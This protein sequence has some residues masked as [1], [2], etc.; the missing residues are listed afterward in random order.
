[1]GRPTLVVQFRADGSGTEIVDQPLRVGFV[2]G[3]PVGPA[4]V[5]NRVRRRLRHLVR[6]RLAAL[7]PL[8]PGGVLIVRATPAAAG[9]TGVRL[10]ADLEAALARLTDQVE[11]SPPRE[12]GSRG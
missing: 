4:V 8:A 3:R 11:L 12:A 10:A 9:A 2:V 6:D 1:V 5:R 7:T